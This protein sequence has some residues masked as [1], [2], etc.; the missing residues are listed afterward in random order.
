MEKRPHPVV[1][2]VKFQTFH[3]TC[4][5]WKLVKTAYQD[6]KTAHMKCVNKQSLAMQTMNTYRH[7]VN[8]RWNMLF[9]VPSEVKHVTLRNSTPL[10]VRLS[11]SE[12]RDAPVMQFV[13]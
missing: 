8:S 1:F 7:F 12:V 5:Q 11:S 13:K 10:R 2:D 4:N 9:S 3:V 6:S